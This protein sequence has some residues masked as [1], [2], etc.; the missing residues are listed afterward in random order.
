[1][2][3]DSHGNQSSSASTH[4]RSR[5]ALKAL[6]IDNESWLIQT[7]A[8]L[9]SSTAESK[10]QLW[11]STRSAATSFVGSP[12]TEKEGFA[13][14]GYKKKP[15]GEDEP[16]SPVL[17]HIGTRRSSLAPSTSGSGILKYGY[18]YGGR[19]APN[20]RFASRAASKKGSR[21]NLLTP[22]GLRT[23]GEGDP[24]DEAGRDYFETVSVDF[25][26]DEGFDEEEGDENG[27]LDAEESELRRL[28]YARVGGWVDW[29][30]GWMDWRDGLE[31]VL[32]EEDEE[33]SGNGEKQEGRTKTGEEQQETGAEK[34]RER[35]KRREELRYAETVAMG[36]TRGDVVP[37]VPPP[38][39]QGERGAGVVGDTRWFLGLA[40]KI[41]VQ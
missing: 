30:V 15:Y 38:A 3:T 4:R 25:A 14:E 23:P 22:L 41:L 20:S 28:V 21:V 24:L 26:D 34:G 17:S 18:N 35:R 39:R 5:S 11:L 13:F 7:A 33:D 32:G 16:R 19:S 2:D 37:T 8:T 40:R 27:D 6:E 36:S 31:G 10:G 1:M 9:A 29:A 12:Q